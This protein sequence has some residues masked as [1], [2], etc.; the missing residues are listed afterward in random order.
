MTDYL[1]LAKAEVDT[2]P[3]PGESFDED[4]YLKIAPPTALSAI[5]YALIALVERLDKLTDEDSQA[6]RTVVLR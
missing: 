3:K 2:L 1:A 5:A 4:E 6:I